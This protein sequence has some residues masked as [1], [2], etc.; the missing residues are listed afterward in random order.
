ML[1]TDNEST[2]AIFKMQAFFKTN[3]TVS[4]AEESSGSLRVL[5]TSQ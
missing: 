4:P 5:H 2:K 1:E 3:F